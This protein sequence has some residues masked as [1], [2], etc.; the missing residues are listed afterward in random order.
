MKNDVTQTTPSKGKPTP[1]NNEKP[2]FFKRMGR[3]IKETFGE[4]KKVT[5]PTFGQ[6]MKQLGAVIAVVLCFLVVL[7]LFDWLLSLGFQQFQTAL[8][9]SVR[10]LLN[11]FIPNL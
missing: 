9:A 7:T 2:G 5:W 3:A 6:T 11:L 1:K 8:G 4:L 10:S